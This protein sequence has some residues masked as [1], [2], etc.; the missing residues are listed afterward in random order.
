MDPQDPQQP[1]HV[2]DAVEPGPDAL[3]ALVAA[4]LDD[5]D[6]VVEEVRVGGAVETPT[7]EVVLDRAHGSEGLTLDEVAAFSGRVSAALDAAGDHIPGVG[8]GE[9]MLEVTTAGVD[10][11]LTQR[12]HFERSVGRL[13]S[14]SVDGAEPVTAR[15][16][17]VGEDDV[18]LVVVRP[19]AKK[20]MPSKEL[21]PERVRLD[22]LGPAVVQVEWGTAR[23]PGES[24]DRAEDIAEHTEA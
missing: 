4:A 9:Y 20:G 3:R 13:I 2:H 7:V 6:V 24:P 22:R 16:R 1:E 5:A 17:E 14:V 8:A 19:G 18:E 15:L 10:R 11:P 12:R 23:E 21:P